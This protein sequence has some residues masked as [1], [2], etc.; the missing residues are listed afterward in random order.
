MALLRGLRDPYERNFLAAPRSKLIRRYVL[1]E[2]FHRK[3]SWYCSS[4]S[5]FNLFPDVFIVFLLLVQ[6][7]TAATRCALESR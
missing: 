2:H 6:E 7:L 5:A 3:P 1:P 4:Y